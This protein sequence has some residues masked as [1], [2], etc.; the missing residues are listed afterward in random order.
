[1]IVCAGKNES[2]PFATSIGVGLIESAMNLTRICMFDKPDYIIFIGSAGS[3]GNYNLFDIIESSSASNLEL[4]FLD[5]NSYTPIDNVLKCEEPKFQSDTI[6]NSSNY[7]TTNKK[8]GSEFLQYDIGIEN[9]EFFSV[10]KIAQEFEI[11]VK[12][13]FVVTNM[14]NEDAHKDFIS[15][16]SDAM[17]K[18]VQHLENK[19]MIVPRGTTLRKSK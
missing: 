6:V 8:L 17:D 1:M 9:M 5:G 12:G 19:K 14:T 7:I 13:I 10:V 3:Y 16:H 4:S 11:D 15:N 18:L 2:F